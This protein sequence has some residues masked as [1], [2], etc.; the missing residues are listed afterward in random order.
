MVALT[1]G[2]GALIA[3]DYWKF[4]SIWQRE[5][6]VMARIDPE[7]VRPPFDPYVLT[8]L[9]GLLELE[10]AE[11]NHALNAMGLD[12]VA[13]I[14]SRYPYIPLVMKWA[15][16]SKQSG[17]AAYAQQLIDRVCLREGRQRCRQ[18]RESYERF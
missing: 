5:R 10:R 16:A 7:G 14:A 9:Q 2:L 4:E 18:I 3:V 15:V 6:F 11:P 12:K 13:A 17:Q 1:W 8:Q